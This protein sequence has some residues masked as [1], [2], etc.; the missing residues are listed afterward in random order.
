MVCPNPN[1]FDGQISLQRRD[2]EEPSVVATTTE[3][4]SRGTGVLDMARAI[5]TGTARTERRARWP[6]TCSTR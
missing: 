2:D 6:T 4:S 1:M 5:R 3:Q